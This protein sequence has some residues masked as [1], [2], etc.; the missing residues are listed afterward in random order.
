[1]GQ[2]VN[3]IM[4]VTLESWVP[5][6]VTENCSLAMDFRC[7]RTDRVEGDDSRRDFVWAGKLRQKVRLVDEKGGAGSTT[8]NARIAFCSPGRFVVS[9]CAR[10]SRN[11]TSGD[12]AEE[13]W[14][15]PVAQ[16]VM[17]EESKLP[18]Q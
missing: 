17:V 9:A 14:W 7:A 8:H 4:N 3:V 5:K 6:D 11:D 18:A 16:T 2:P 13:I 10:F 15:A 1:M 12:A